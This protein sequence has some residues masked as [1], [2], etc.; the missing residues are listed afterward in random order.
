MP[1]FIQLHTL[2]AYPATLLNRDD[3][4]YA[5]RLPFG[6]G[7]RTRVSS[8]CLKKHWRD[9]AGQHAIKDLAPVSVRS[10]IA[11]DHH[12]RQPLVAA[13]VADDI[14][15]GIAATLQKLVIG[16]SSKRSKPAKGED[17]ATPDQVKTSQVVVLGQPE[18]DYLQG[19]AREIAA[20]DGITA[21]NAEK[22]ATDHLG[23]RDMKTNLKALGL[24][25]G[26]NAALFGRMVTGDVL[27][28]MDAA[29]H[30]AHA[31]TVHGED[32]EPD[33]FTVVDELQ[34]DAGTGHVNTTELTTGLYYGY[35]VVD[36]E[37]LVKNLGDDR[38][39]ARRSPSG[40]CT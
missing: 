4:G 27:A 24:A 20:L 16:E 32:S 18:I 14:A 26:L 31:F 22:M 38:D 5:K 11:F 15:F 7:V 40:S 29:I 6:D 21:K 17:E 1:K 36:V 8:Q 34:T 25:S 33:Y 19:L 13:G 10:R 35:V 12:I 37:R 3:A 28:Q 2:T 30:V 9:S 39:L 23:G